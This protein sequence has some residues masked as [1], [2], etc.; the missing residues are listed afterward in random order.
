[1]HGKNVEDY[2]IIDWSIIG[3]LNVKKRG[4]FR[5]EKRDVNLVEAFL[6]GNLENIFTYKIHL[7]QIVFLQ[8][9]NFKEK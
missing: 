3:V 5:A 6:N 2:I 9:E 7:K 4:R 1:M 8:I